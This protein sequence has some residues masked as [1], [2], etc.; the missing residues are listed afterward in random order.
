MGMDVFG[1]EP[2][3]KAGEYFRNNIWWWRPLWDYCHH[4]GGEL[5][6]EETFGRGHCNEGVGLDKKKSE[7]LAKLLTEEMRSGRTKKYEREHMKRMK[8]LPKEKCK[9]CDGTGSRQKPP[10]I[11]AGDMPCNGCHGKG[12]V[13]SFAANYPFSVENVKEFVEF[14]ENCGGF[15]IC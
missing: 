13:E 15:E 5:I 10:N 8:E 9:I 6:D 4:V 7:A 2:K 11:G 12:M 3:N 14:L 1:K